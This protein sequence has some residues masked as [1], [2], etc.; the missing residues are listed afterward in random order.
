MFLISE[1]VR[2]LTFMGHPSGG[3]V[4]VRA[5]SEE[6]LAGTAITLSTKSFGID[7]EI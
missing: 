3:A 5:A 2:R 6:P 4:A 7:L 1:G